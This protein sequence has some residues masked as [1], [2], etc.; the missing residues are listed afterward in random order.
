MKNS[1][2]AIILF[3]IFCVGFFAG[4]YTAP[5]PRVET[6]TDTVR[7]T[8]T[9]VRTLPPPK[10]RVIVKR[11]VVLQHV[12]TAAILAAYFAHY[13]YADTLMNDTSAFIALSETVTQNSI[14]E[15]NLMFQ[16]RRPTAVITTTT[17]LPPPSAQKWQLYGGAIVGKNV[18][19]PVVQIGYNRWLFGTGYNLQQGGVVVEVGWRIR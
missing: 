8:T 1:V 7:D 11:E 10:P 19:A 12:D 4:R 5:Q 3:V 15:R 2:T 6:V 13:F 9:I 17:V 18:A 14:V 16:N